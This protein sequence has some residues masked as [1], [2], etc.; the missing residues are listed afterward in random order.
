MPEESKKPQFTPLMF[1]TFLK[2]A[3]HATGT[4]IFRSLIVKNEET[5]EILDIL[6]DGEYSCS[7]FVSGLLALCKFLPEPCT[8]VASLEKQLAESKWIKIDSEKIKKGD[9][10]IWEEVAFEDGSRNRHVGIAVSETEAVSTSYQTK[11]VV[12]HRI[13]FDMNTNGEPKRRIESVFR[14]IE[15]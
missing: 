11:V 5:G 13:T 2:A 14:Y 4:G 1:E 12:Q 3:E 9:I 6:K 10:I 8:T 7:F 15:K